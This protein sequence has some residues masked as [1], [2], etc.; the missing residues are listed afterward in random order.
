[1]KWV[2]KD[3]QKAQQNLKKHGVRFSE[4]IPALRGPDGLTIADFESDP[5]EE[6][7]ITMGFGAQGDLLVVVYNFRG[8]NIRIISARKANS[9]EMEQYRAQ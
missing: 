8:N 7:W 3:I 5:A 1:M 4:A 2:L 9:N 6:R